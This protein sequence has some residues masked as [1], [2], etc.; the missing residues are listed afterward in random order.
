MEPLHAVIERE[1]SKD[2]NAVLCYD[3]LQIIF[4]W[5]LKN[6]YIFFDTILIFM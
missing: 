4:N 3:R 6:G 5:R 2:L 1:S